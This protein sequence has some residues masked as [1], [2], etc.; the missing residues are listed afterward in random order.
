[1][2][3]SGI[4]K[5]LGSVGIVALLSSSSFGASLNGVSLGNDIVS[6]C[7][8]IRRSKLN[9]KNQIQLDKKQK[10]C[11]YESGYNILT[12]DASGKIISIRFPVTV[13]GLS[14][15]DGAKSHS[16]KYLNSKSPVV[17]KL[18]YIKEGNREFYRGIDLFKQY[19][20]TVDSAF[21]ELESI[22]DEQQ[23][24]N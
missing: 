13:F 7:D 18:D 4:S 3:I 12:A 14:F 23:N 1:M 21:I 9:N 10:T 20:I 15:L 24:F 8:N 19:K 6:E 11:G 22:I 17:D 5:I 16:E 2:K